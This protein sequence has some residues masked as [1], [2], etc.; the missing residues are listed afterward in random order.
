MWKHG[1][2]GAVLVGSALAQVTQ[3]VSVGSGAVQGND[4]SDYPSIS[5]DGRRGHLD[6]CF[7]GDR[8]RVRGGS[9]VAQPTASQ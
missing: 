3:R 8:I 7:A 5:A 1:L 4:G 2:V 9:G 6:D